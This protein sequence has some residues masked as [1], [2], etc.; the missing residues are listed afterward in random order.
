MPAAERIGSYIKR[1]EQA[2]NAAKNAALKPAGVTV[3]QYA[4]LLGL[5]EN[6][7]ISAA[8]L[9][10]LCGV[11]PPTMNTVLTNLVDRGLIERTPH[12]WHRNVLETRLT[13]AGEKAMRDADARA[14]AVERAVAAGFTEDERQTLIDLLTRCA[15]LFDATRA[16]APTA[17]ERN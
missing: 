14:I 10:R 11:T 8:A 4:A 3:A 17:P 13:E 16:E 9:A 1:A 7:G 15:D 12:A 5:V 2:L 6:P